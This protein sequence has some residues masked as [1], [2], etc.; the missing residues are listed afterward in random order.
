MTTISGV[1]TVSSRRLLVSVLAVAGTVPY[2]TLKI[3]WLS[4]SR[5]GLLDPEFGRSATMHVANAA[6]LLMDATAILLAVAFVA[7][8]RR[9]VP[10]PFVLAP[11]WVGT[12]LLAP[13]VVILP[14][15][16]VIGVPESSAAGPAAIADWVYLVVYAGF[17]WQGVFLM[18]GF[19]LWARERWGGVAGRP[20]GSTPATAT[21]RGA[22]ALLAVAA[23]LVVLGA[24]DH[25][26]IAWPNLGGDLAAVLAAGLGLALLHLG[27]GP[28]W[29]P[30]VLTWLGS[31]ALLTWGVY[32]LVLQTVP[33]DLVDASTV[34]GL[35]IATQTT[36]VVAGLAVLA[37]ATRSA[38]VLRD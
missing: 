8:W 3:A 7:R 16:L 18:L 6:T 37:A 33:N 26:A 29:R 10:S 36:R 31:G 24:D 20:L 15:Q 38:K 28:R 5:I 17:F 11:M 34:T 32:Q 1:P 14:L 25:G 13:V 35:D 27:T 4:G 19:V 30:V 9:R 12:G 22:W 2:L 23:V 21:S